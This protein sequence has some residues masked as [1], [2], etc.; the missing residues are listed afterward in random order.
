M[1]NFQSVSEVQTQ[2][3]YLYASVRAR[4][5]ISGARGG[6]AG[7]FLYNNDTNESDIE[8]LTNDDK[9]VYRLTN[10]P[11]VDK[12]GNEIPG[13]STTDPIPA[14]GGASGNG[15]WADWNDWRLDW[16]DGRSDWYVNGKLVES[17]EYG[18]MKVECQFVL[19]MW[20]NGGIWS[21]NM[22]IGDQAVMDVEWVEMVYNISSEVGKACDNA[23]M[24]DV[25][26]NKDLGNPK[27]SGAPLLSVWSWLWLLVAGVLWQSVT[28]GL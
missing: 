22:T 17:K 12:D 19:N 18:V 26:K 28:Y 14:A 6:V 24:C 11:G 10:N 15:S 3:A 1:P 20:S 16:F 13:A 9:S 27:L 4:A 8:I 7:I 2:Q 23:K 25:D 5:R 21:G